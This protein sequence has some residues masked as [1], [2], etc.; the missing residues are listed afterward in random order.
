MVRQSDVNMRKMTKLMKSVI[1]IALAF[2]FIFAIGCK[3]AGDDN[4]ATIVPRPPVVQDITLKNT[5]LSM[6]VPGVT[7]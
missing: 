3:P 2:V 1:S 5:S 4:T 7:I 6:T